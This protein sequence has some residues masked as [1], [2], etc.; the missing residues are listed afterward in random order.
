MLEAKNRIDGRQ[1]RYIDAERCA[2][3]TK[4]VAAGDDMS[5]L[6]NEL[7]QLRQQMAA[8]TTIKSVMRTTTS[9]K[10]YDTYNLLIAAS[11]TARSWPLLTVS[12]P[13]RQPAAAA[14]ALKRC[15]DHHTRK[16][17]RQSQTH[18]RHD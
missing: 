12:D 13:D 7:H 3:G 11:A 17:G 10:P 16:G 5:S 6:R 8:M 9:A 1:E 2:I 15:Q 18:V 4:T 14:S